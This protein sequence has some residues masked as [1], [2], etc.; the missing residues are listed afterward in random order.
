MTYTKSAAVCVYAHPHY[1]VK[2]NNIPE[3]DAGKQLANLARSIQRDCMQ[4]LAAFSTSP[5]SHR[6][7]VAGCWKMGSIIDKACVLGFS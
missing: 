3:K 7:N 5:S 1:L 4:L 2:V 6:N